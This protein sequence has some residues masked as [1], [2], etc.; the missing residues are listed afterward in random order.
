MLIYDLPQLFEVLFFS[1]SNKM[2]LSHLLF[3][4]LL[5]INSLLVHAL[6]SGRDGGERN[7]T[8][9]ETSAGPLVSKPN[10]SNNTC[11]D[12]TKSF[13]DIQ[14]LLVPIVEEFK[15]K[16]AVGKSSSLQFQDLERRVEEAVRSL[17]ADALKDIFSCSICLDKITDCTKVRYK[18]SFMS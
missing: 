2:H 11:L 18:L 12:F 13:Q 17:N 3:T 1:L 4:F 10:S 7:E 6:P 5:V 8:E 15:I 14:S 9:T 16:A